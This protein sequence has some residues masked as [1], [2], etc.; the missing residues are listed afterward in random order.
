MLHLNIIFNIMGLMLTLIALVMPTGIAFSLYY[1]DD[2][3]D[4]LLISTGITFTVGVLLF[5]LTSIGGRP[6]YN[7]LRKREGYVIVAL[8]WA[9]I[10]TFGA[11]PYY[12]YGGIP[13][14]TDAYFESM[15]GFT[16]TGA[17]ILTDIEALPHGLLF[18]RNLTQWL[19]GIGIIVFSLAILPLL[20][21]GG[22]QLFIAEV[23][24]P[25]KDK[26][27][28]H[29][30][31]TA[32]R[33]WGI[34][35][36]LTVL[37]ALLYMAGG[38]NLFEALCHA[39]GTL[40]TGG[41]SPKNDSIAHYDSPF[42]QYTFIV[43]MFLGGVN[44][45]LHYHFIQ[46]RLMSYF[47][48]EEFLFYLGVVIVNIAFITGII[49]YFQDAY[50]VEKALRDATFQVISIITGT[51]YVTADYE[52]WSHFTPFIFFVLMFA[53]A[54]AGST[55]GG[56]KMIR[57]LLLSKNG[58]LELKR[59]LHPRAVVPVR[60]NGRLVQP[61]VIGNI[62]AFF[63]LYMVIFINGSLVMSII[64]LDFMS[65]MGSVAATLS[66]VGPGIGGVGPAHNYSE[67]PDLGKWFLCFMMLLGRLELFTILVIFSPAFWRA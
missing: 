64:G 11:L 20:G 24:G 12:V 67:I 52:A 43:F 47:R 38:M 26:I 49:L 3:I 16:T 21:I 48:D 45:G 62:V 59:L 61:H 50:T 63:V 41:F 58:L 51:G 34:Y 60:I 37:A 2:D 57:L 23:G 31:G 13:S 18:W 66:C 65:A 32:K 46:G 4:A 22:T 44:F 54:S 10:S 56:M 14:F 6:D 17:S 29:V 35:V 15:S 28:P 40:A 9:V 5:G 19:G 55:T 30:Q 53:G 8:A 25:N 7:N 1:G 39:F 33:L 42:I 36:S 27:H